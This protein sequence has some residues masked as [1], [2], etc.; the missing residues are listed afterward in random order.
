MTDV[1][2]P[3][4]SWLRQIAGWIATFVAM[5]VVVQGVGWLRAPALPDEAPDFTLADLDGA[6]VSLSDFRGH[7]VVVNFWATWCGP[8]RMEIP[9]FSAFSDANPDVVVLGVAADGPA[10]KLRKA[11]KDLG[12][13]YTVLQGDAATLAAYG[14]NTFPTTV[15]V[16]P[17]GAVQ[18][19]HTGILLRPQ[20]AWLAGTWW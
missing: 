1:E 13:T 2:S 12:I 4:S 9:S 19:A 17:D 11:S 14:V 18:A 5:V 7:T 3:G 20:L 8:C 16:G 6:P 10:G 15:I